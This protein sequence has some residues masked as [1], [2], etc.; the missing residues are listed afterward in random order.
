LAAPA[1]GRCTEI[2][3]EPQECRLEFDITTTEGSNRVLVLRRGDEQRR[4]DLSGD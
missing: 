3:L 4:W 2:T 1:A